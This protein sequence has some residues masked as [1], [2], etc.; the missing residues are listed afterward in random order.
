ML[1]LLNL[2]PIMVKIN[3]IETVENKNE[4]RKYKATTKKHDRCIAI[5]CNL[6]S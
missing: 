2:F 6:Q 5:L 1:L 3:R 4:S